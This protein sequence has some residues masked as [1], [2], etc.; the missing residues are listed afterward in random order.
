MAVFNPTQ[1]MK[2]H[3]LLHG[4]KTQMASCLK[5]KKNGRVYVTPT[6]VST[7]TNTMLMLSVMALVVM[8]S[9]MAQVVMCNGN[10]IMLSHFFRSFRVNVI[11]YI[12]VLYVVV[13]PWIKGMV[14]HVPA[15]LCSLPHGLHDTVVISPPPQTCGF[16]SLWI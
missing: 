3:S 5:S 16:L 10:H 13:N 2:R 1:E 4:I 14:S 9:V 15:G 11:T 8:L 6:K 7:I 12:K